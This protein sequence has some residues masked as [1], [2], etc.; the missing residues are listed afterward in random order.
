[1]TFTQ[2]LIQFATKHWLMCG[3]FV[4]LLVML[5]IEEARSKGLGS[6]LSVQQAVDLMNHEQAVV[7]D[8]R[9]Q[10]TFKAEHIV[11]AINIPKSNLEQSMNRLV[12]FKQRPIIVVCAAGQHSVQV[13]MQLRKQ[14]FEK[15]RALAKG[16][17]GWKN[18]SMPMKK[19]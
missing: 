16:I 14:G 19:R 5:F 15:A 1:M 18:E 6:Q 11:N 8:L 17:Q 2:Q 9:D 13:A 3:A 12:N 10:V 7:L 4:V